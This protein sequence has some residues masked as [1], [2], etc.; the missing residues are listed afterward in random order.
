MKDLYK[1]WNKRIIQNDSRS[2]STV[3]G[4]ML[5]VAIVTTSMSVLISVTSE[6]N[7]LALDKESEAYQEH[8]ELM[9]EMQEFY[10]LVNSTHTGYTD[11]KSIEPTWYWPENGSIDI[12]LKPDCKVYVDGPSSSV[13]TVWYRF[14]GIDTSYTAESS[15]AKY[16]TV[17]GGTLVTFKYNGASLPNTTY[18]WKVIIFNLGK[19]STIEAYLSFTTGPS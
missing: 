8:Y 4:S 1:I 7:R 5:L 15:A 10:Y 17:E 9:Q 18:Y 6:S 14:Y 19:M 13:A 11:N 16:K 12:P 3:V 2:I